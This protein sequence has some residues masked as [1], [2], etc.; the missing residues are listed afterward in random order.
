MYRLL[1]GTRC[2]EMTLWGNGL[3]GSHVCT[4]CNSAAALSQVTQSL[5]APSVKHLV[6]ATAASDT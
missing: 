3:C 6:A 2:I 4:P 5:S 1:A